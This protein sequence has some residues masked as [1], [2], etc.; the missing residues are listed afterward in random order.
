[1]SLMQLTLVLLRV[2]IYITCCTCSYH[3][4]ISV[5][6]QWIKTNKTCPQCRSEW[7]GVDKYVTMANGRTGIERVHYVNINMDEADLLPN[8]TFEP[9]TGHFTVT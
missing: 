5:Y 1:M 8:E 9:K 2:N 4:H 7:K 3:F 6:D